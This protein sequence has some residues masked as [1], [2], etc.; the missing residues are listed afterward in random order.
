MRGVDPEDFILLLDHQPCEQEAVD[1]AG[2]DLM[3]SGH[4]HAGQIWPVG[5]ISQAAG[6][7]EMNY[8]YRKL[9]RLQV[10]VSSGLVGWGYPIR[11][12]RHCEYVVIEVGNENKMKGAK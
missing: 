3:L 12:S 5:Q 6:I 2:C 8:G 1:A 10:I 7:V 11:T 9:N 4:T